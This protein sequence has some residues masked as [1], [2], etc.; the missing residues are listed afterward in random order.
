MNATRIVFMSGCHNKMMLMFK[1]SA[2]FMDNKQKEKDMSHVR[3]VC[4]ALKTIIISIGRHVLWLLKSSLSLSILSFLSN[5]VGWVSVKTCERASLLID[6]H[7]A[8]KF[9]FF[10]NLYIF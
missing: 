3:V 2:N 7:H 9:L 1:F 6:S 10:E 8:I 5:I 4:F